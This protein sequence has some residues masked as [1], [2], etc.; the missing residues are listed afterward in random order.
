[1]DAAPP[2]PTAA[3]PGSASEP[4]IVSA[5][6]RTPETN[7]AATV[8]PD[9]A[10]VIRLT[11]SAAR[12]DGSLSPSEEEAILSHARSVGAEHVVADELRTPTPLARLVADVPAP[13]RSDLYT[14]GYGI[15]Q[16][17]GSVTGAERIFLAQLAHGLGLDAAVA[18]ALE[19]EAARRIT[20]AS[21]QEGTSTAPGT[22]N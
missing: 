7:E 2:G 13:A 17:D 1:V 6:R 22:S 14:L 21:S 18:A 8:A 10:R 4:A 16:A 19:T 12:A 3:D 9:A 15:I 11:V 20:A 5:S